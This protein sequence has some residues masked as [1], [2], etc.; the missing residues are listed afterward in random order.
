[1]TVSV[2]TLQGWLDA[3]ENEHLECKE[4][5]NMVRWANSRMDFAP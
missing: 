3:K 4:A 2:E 5:D 1:M